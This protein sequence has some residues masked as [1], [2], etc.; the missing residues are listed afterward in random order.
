MTIDKIGG[1]SNIQQKSNVKYNDKVSKTGSDRIEI[2][3]ESRLALQNER[4]I[5]IV[6]EAPDVREE[7]IAEA[8]QRLELY[9]KD[10]ALR[11]EVLN[12]L[13]NSI[14]DSMPLD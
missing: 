4:L 10:G 12:S 3:N 6:K 1:T 7:K 9:M 14:I 2:S 8:K 13:A 11:E 5:N